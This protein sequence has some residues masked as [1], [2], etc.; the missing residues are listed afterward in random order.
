MLQLQQGGT[1]PRRVVAPSQRRMPQQLRGASSGAQSVAA[2]VAAAAAA[3]WPL[4]MERVVTAAALRS[5]SRCRSRFCPCCGRRCRRCRGC[6]RNC[7]GCSGAAARPPSQLRPTGRR[8][9]D[10]PAAP[11]GRSKSGERGTN[12]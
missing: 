3:A 5:L 2:V 9:A 10:R 4:S 1:R 8:R 11:K 6:C 12:S 7:R